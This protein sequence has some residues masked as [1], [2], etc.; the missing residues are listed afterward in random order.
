MN[1]TACRMCQSTGLNLLLDLGCQPP[2][3]AFLTREQLDEPE[4]TYPLKILTCNDCGLVQLSYTVPGEAIFNNQYVYEP[5]TTQTARGHFFEL[6]ESI[7]N[8]FSL[9][10]DDLAVDAGSNIGLLLD[11][12]R[13]AGTRVCGVDPV[14][15]LAEIARQN[16]LPTITGFLNATSAEKVISTHGS[17]AVVTGTNV[18]A[19]TD[20]PHEFVEAVKMMLATDGVLVVEAPSFGVMVEK[21]W[22]D[23]LYHEHRMALSLT[24]T[25]KF[26]ERHGLETFDVELTEFHGGSLRIFA[27]YP[28]YHMVT[29]RVGEMLRLEAA[30]ELHSMGTLRAFADRVRANRVAITRMLLDLKAAGKRIVAISA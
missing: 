29:P 25:V 13:T 16:G 1:A 18:L 12:F 7:V 28:G 23:Q 8:R 15:K 10:R 4:M 9:G 21:M 11:G 26:F 6:A 19:H 30:K 2:S 14:D 17:A 27:S 3:N 5:S 22:W 20:S 24:P